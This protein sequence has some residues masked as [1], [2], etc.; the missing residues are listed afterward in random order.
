MS[1]GTKGL[2]LTGN[3]MAYYE[4]TN[5]VYLRL[6]RIWCVAGSE[7]NRPDLEAAWK[8]NARLEQ[9]LV[10]EDICPKCGANE[11]S[12]FCTCTQDKGV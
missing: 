2:N 5:P 8:E 9:L 7:F 4:C 10:K 1:T 12:R 3:D 6:R 11:A